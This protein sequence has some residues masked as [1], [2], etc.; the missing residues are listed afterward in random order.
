M[1]IFAAKSALAITIA[2][3]HIISAMQVVN[4]A[5]YK[6]VEVPNPSDWRAILKERADQ[7]KL[8]GSFIIAPEGVNFFMAGERSSVDAFLDFLRNDEMFSGRFKNIDVKESISDDQ[9]FRR[10]VVRLKKE[11][12]TM[13]HPMICPG[14]MRAPSVDAKTLKR[15]LDQGHDDS[16]RKVVLLDT[17]NN[18]EV[19]IGTF[20]GALNLQIEQFSDFPNAVVGTAGDIRAELQDKTIVSFCTGGIRCEKAALFLRELEFDNVFQLDGGILRYFED[21]GGAHWQGE[22]FVFDRRVALDPQLQ[23]TTRHYETTAH[24][25]RNARYLKWKEQQQNEPVGRAE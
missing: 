1:P 12:I 7:L 15:W 3:A 25:D 6:F 20:N 24:P 16:G 19:E 18:F 4:I 10:M 23:T 8:M 2:F 17:R 22:C 5:A 9:P 21:V 13:K 11:I 14:E